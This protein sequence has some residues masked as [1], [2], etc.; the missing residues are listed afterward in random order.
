MKFYGSK[1]KVPPI[2][3]RRKWEKL[4]REDS[5]EWI[6]IAFLK[7]ELRVLK[8]FPATD[9]NHKLIKQYEDELNKTRTA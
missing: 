2:R 5:K 7:S 3:D 9:R 4:K 6:R 1:F 8:N